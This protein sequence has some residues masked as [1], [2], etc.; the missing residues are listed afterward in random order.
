MNPAEHTRI[1]NK[2]RNLPAQMERARRRLRDLQREAA[3]YGMHEL[4]PPD[5]SKDTP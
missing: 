5:F 1:V 2:Q 4:L 3:R